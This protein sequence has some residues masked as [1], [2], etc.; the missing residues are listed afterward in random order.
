MFRY[1]QLLTEVGLKKVDHALNPTQSV[2]KWART[3][4]ERTVAM[5]Y[6]EQ[7]DFIAA[8]ATDEAYAAAFGACVDTTRVHT[9]DLQATTEK[10][11]KIAEQAVEREIKREPEPET[12]AASRNRLADIRKTMLADMLVDAKRKR[13]QVKA[14]GDIVMRSTMV[15]PSTVSIPHAK[16]PAKEKRKRST[17]TPAAAEGS[18]KPKM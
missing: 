9:T 17:T 2:L 18:K 3:E 14:Q 13:A 4:K 10:E 12:T 6:F 8:Q 7:S 16:A 11:L 5:D 15:D 1:F